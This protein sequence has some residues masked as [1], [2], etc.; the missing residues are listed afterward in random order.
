[1]TAT[2][3]PF[4]MRSSRSLGG[5]FNTEGQNRYRITNGFNQNIGLGDPVALNT[6]GTLVPV[7][8]NASIAVGVF[9][10]CMY[11]DPLTFK[12]T[13]AKRF[14]AATSSANESYVT[15][16]VIDDP[17]R[18][19]VMQATASVSA[20]DVGYAFNVTTGSGSDTYWGISSYALDAG[21]R[22]NLAP[23]TV[24]L[25]DVLEEPGNAFADAYPIVE[26]RIME[27]DYAFTSAS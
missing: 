10:G 1:M 11:V 25:I 12:P 3:A 18:N 7:S 22:T 20:G 6:A 13:W 15:G 19:F 26:V 16:F 2:F 27:H 9:A 8:A 17:R 14:V 24:Q 4:G 23:R 21:S 5:G